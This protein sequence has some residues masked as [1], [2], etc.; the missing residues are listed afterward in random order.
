MAGIAGLILTGG[1]SRRMGG[2][3]KT[4]LPL[5]GRPLLAHVVERLRPQVAALA[6]S[7]NGD[8]ARFA[9]WRLPVVADDIPDFAGPLAGILAGME[10]AARQVPDCRWLVSVPGD[11]PLLPA[12]LVVRLRAAV[13]AEGASVACAAS[14]GRTHP[15][16]ALWPLALADALRHALVDEG[17]RKVGLWAARH[18]VAVVSWPAEPLDPFANVNTPEDLAALDALLG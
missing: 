2:G 16:T 17:V 13:E 1:R 8:P 4:L 10:W 5:A 3:D 9:D 15:V 7:A 12:D 11:A 18:N 6:L 14:A